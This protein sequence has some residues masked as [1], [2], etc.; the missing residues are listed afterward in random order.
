LSSNQ[1]GWL[2]KLVGSGQVEE[3]MRQLQAREEQVAE[4]QQRLHEALKL[5]ESEERRAKSLDER[6]L[7]LVGRC[8][9]LEQQNSYLES[10][11][12]ASKDAAAKQA[13]E[14]SSATSRAVAATKLASASEQRVAAAAT[15]LKEQ[16][17]VAAKAQEQVASLTETQLQLQQAAAALTV[18]LEAHERVIAKTRA[19]AAALTQAR[20]KLEEALAESRREQHQWR[21]AL[22]ALERKLSDQSETAKADASRATRRLSEAQAALTALRHDHERFVDE[23]ADL[24]ELTVRSLA[25]ALGDGLPLALML[26]ERTA[27]AG[28]SQRLLR[29]S[30]GS[31]WEQATG[32]LMRHGLVDVELLSREPLSLRVRPRQAGAEVLAAWAAGVVGACLAEPSSVSALQGLTRDDS[33]FVAVYADKAGTVAA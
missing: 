10:S 7:D 15:K 11:L 8:N 33:G 16:E 3:L 31:S 26:V 9:E 23:A 27:L 4:Q 25:G 13:E 12:A 19:E 32:L 17:R 18:K 24:L 14:L 21:E 30:A 2:S 1:G 29:S 28:L 6:V 20:A 22:Q 5:W